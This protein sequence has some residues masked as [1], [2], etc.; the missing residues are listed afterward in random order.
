MAVTMAAVNFIPKSILSVVLLAVLPLYAQTKPANDCSAS[1]T[2]V[3][4]ITGQPVA[5]AMVILGDPANSTNGAASDATGKWTIANVPCVPAS[6]SA[7]KV[8]FLE[9]YYPVTQVPLVSGSPL[10]DVKIRMMPEGVISGRVQDT[11]GEPVARADIRVLIVSVREG[12]RNLWARIGLSTDSQ[13]NFRVDG[14]EPGSYSVCA[15]SSRLTYP[16]GGGGANVFLEDC[17]PGTPSAGSH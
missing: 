14:L 9:H 11:N 4:A 10:N 5:G 6:P 12:K 13:G 8:G 17:Y 1:G 7:R 15:A 16:V 3:N 2:V